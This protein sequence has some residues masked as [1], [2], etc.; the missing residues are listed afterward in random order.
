MLEK[1][2]S[3]AEDKYATR[4]AI[5]FVVDDP[6]IGE[7]LLIATSQE[8]PYQALLAQTSERAI[9]I[10][11]HVKPALFVLDYF[12]GKMNGIDLYDR[13]HAQQSL[14]AIPAIFLSANLRELQD[15]IDHRHLVGLA[16]PFALDDLLQS[17]RQALN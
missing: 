11:R 13:L 17:I 4:K 8:T 15:E 5:L 6:Y 1:Q 16:K 10:V 7:L 12:P 14:E 9:E 2:R 3:R